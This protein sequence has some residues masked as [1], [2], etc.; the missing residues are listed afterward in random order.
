VQ[1][2]QKPKTETH[3]DKFNIGDSVIVY[4]T[5]ETGIVYARA[6]EKGEVGVQIKGKKK[7]VKHKRLKL[8]VAASEL[9]PENYDFS[10]IFDSV[11]DRKARHLMGK[12]HQEGNIIVKEKDEKS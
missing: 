12:R 10:I 6:N 5:K 1:K 9:Y 2:E 8:Q 3:R 7:L 11:A 4:P